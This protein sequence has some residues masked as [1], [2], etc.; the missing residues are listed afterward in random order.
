MTFG[1]LGERKRKLTAAVLADRHSSEGKGTRCMSNERSGEVSDSEEEGDI[2]AIGRI[3][4][5]A[6]QR[7]REKSEAVIHSISSL[8]AVDIPCDDKG[9]I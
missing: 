2:G 1:L 7:N 6:L 3:L 4:L 9:E 5:K 8:L